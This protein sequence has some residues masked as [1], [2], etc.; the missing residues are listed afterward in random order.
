METLTEFKKIS[1]LNLNTAKST[2]LRIGS[3]NK[4]NIKF[5]NERPFIWTSQEAKMLGITFC[6]QSNLNVQNNLI[7]KLNEFNTCLK[8]W[9]HRELTLMGKITV[10]KTFALPKL[11]Y[12]FSVLPNPSSIILNNITHS[13]FNF[14]WDNKPDKI[15]RKSLYT[16]YESGGLNLTNI[17]KFLT[18]IKS[19]WIKRYLD[20]ENCGKCKLLWDLRLNKYGNELI[21]ESEL[22]EKL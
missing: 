17:N 2:I 10:I 12:P 13:I 8:Q 20:S 5:C 21:F 15:K 14:I 9:Q 11:I 7:P 16:K 3:L 6:N 4:T 18:S 22:S 1:G 19:S